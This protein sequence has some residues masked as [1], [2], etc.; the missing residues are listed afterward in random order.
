MKAILEVLKERGINDPTILNA[1][2]QVD[3]IHFIP[4]PFQH[5]A[6][7]DMPVSIGSGQTISQPSIVGLMTKELK[8]NKSHRV[9]EIGTGS[10][11]QTAILSYL[12]KHVYTVERVKGLH[13]K[14]KKLLS[15]HYKCSNVSFIFSD[16]ALGHLDAAPY[17]RIIITAAAK[18]V[19][20]RL[21]NQLKQD[22]IMVLPV[23]ENEW[24][25]KLV[26]IKKTKSDVEFNELV[27]VRF[28][29]LV[30]GVAKS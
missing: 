6:Y 2:K 19:P 17:D 4:E 20:R 11:Y 26:S 21:L 3:R 25:Q 15:S 7:S 16:G 24:Q 18:E 28:V 1:I 10:G 23:V 5:C 27:S 12:A 8:V 29:P 9:L 14:A 30:E 22:G 13:D